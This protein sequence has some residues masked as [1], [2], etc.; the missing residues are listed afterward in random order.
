M[1]RRQ[2]RVQ[3]DGTGL[4]TSVTSEDG[5]PLHPR[6]V[7]IFVEHDSVTEV[8]MEFTHVK[9]DMHAEVRNVILTCPI[10]SYTSQHQCD[11]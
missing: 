6:A 3:S 8:D 2:V 1:G 7:S 4:T 10:C 11:D 9:I 5:T